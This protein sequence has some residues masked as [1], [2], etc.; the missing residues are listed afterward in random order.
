VARITLHHLVIGLETG[1]GYFLHRHLLVER[2]FS[3]ELYN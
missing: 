2:L 3:F 1:V